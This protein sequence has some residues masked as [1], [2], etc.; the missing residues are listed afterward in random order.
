MEDSAGSKIQQIEQLVAH[1]NQAA[2]H[3]LLPGK[4]GTYDQ[5]DMTGFMVV[6][7]LEAETGILST[8]PTVRSAEVLS[9]ALKSSASIH[10]RC[11]RWIR[12]RKMWGSF[13]KS[14]WQPECSLIDTDESPTIDAD[15]Y[16]GRS[17]TKAVT[18]VAIRGSGEVIIIIIQVF[19]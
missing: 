5:P 12:Q 6:E 19:E 4:P 8:S 2:R 9:D 18:C 1:L 7:K 14:S 13:T 11:F 10:K 15:L 17:L 16:E 3:V